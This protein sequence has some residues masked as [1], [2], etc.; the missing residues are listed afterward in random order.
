MPTATKP[1]FRYT[2]GDRH[3]YTWNGQTDYITVYRIATDQS[4]SVSYRPTGEAIPA[5]ERRTATAL[6]ATVDTWR[7]SV[8]RHIT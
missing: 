7:S 3:M 2:P 6:M 4:G 5:P 8:G 1:A